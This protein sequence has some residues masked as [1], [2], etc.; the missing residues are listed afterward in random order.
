MKSTR[1][2]RCFLGVILCL[3]FERKAANW[4]WRQSQSAKNNQNET[5]AQS[6][7]S[8]WKRWGKGW[9]RW[10]SQNFR[11]LNLSV[12]V[13]ALLS[14]IVLLIIVTLRLLLLVLRLRNISSTVFLFIWPLLVPTMLIPKHLNIFKLSCRLLRPSW[15]IVGG[16][17]LTKVNFVN[18]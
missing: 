15:N 11:I 14:I 7:L 12:Q 10:K 3:N 5:P 13:A 16:Y 9:R 2:L 8:R 4:L 6:D 18:V 17:R 1:T